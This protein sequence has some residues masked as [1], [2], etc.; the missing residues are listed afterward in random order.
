MKM[1]LALSRGTLRTRSVDGGESHAGLCCGSCVKTYSWVGS[2]T[3]RHAE[4]LVILRK[5]MYIANVV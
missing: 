2:V 1:S 4:P 3:S 5:I